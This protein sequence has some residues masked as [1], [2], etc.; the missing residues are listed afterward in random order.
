M[1]IEYS[2]KNNFEDKYIIKVEGKVIGNITVN[3]E[4]RSIMNIFIVPDFE[5]MGYGTRLVKHVEDLFREKKFPIIRT[6]TITSLEAKNFFSKLGFSID[7]QELGLK[8]LSTE[9]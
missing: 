1:S 4:S 5:R 7:N 9:F 2:G 6:S 3:F 8:I